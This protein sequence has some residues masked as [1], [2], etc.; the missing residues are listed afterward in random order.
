[1]TISTTAH[2]N[3]RGDARA[4]LEF[5]QSVFGGQAAITSYADVGM[6]QDAPGANHVLFG[7]VESPDGFRVMGYDIPGATSGRLA[8]EGSTHREN[9]ATLTDQSCF[10]SVNGQTLDEIEDY[11]EKLSD[12]AT[13]VEPLAASEWSPGFGMLTDRH[14]VTWTFGVTPAS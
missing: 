11:W 6:P 12:G 7:Q 8:G 10:V 4:A 2:L 3:F 5:Y 13:I 1:M 9:G 14:G